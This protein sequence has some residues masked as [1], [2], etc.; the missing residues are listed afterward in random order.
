GV[1]GGWLVAVKSLGIPS[2]PYWFYSAQGVDTWQVAEGL[3]KAVLFGGA[4]GLI[5]CYKG[6]NCGSGASG[7]GRACTESFVSSFIAIIVLNF[8]FAKLLRDWYEAIYGIQGIF[9]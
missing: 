6:F 4:I 2:D 3:I 8:F 1:L 9:G 5:S 7:V